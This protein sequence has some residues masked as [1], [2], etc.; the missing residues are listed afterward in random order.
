MFLAGQQSVRRRQSRQIVWPVSSACLALLS[1]TLGVLLAVPGEPRIVY[2]P[3]SVPAPAN[4][5]T[6]PTP[7]PKTDARLRPT[8]PPQA[9]SES[10][11]V[12]PSE[13]YPRRLAL[14]N[15]VLQ[16]TWG[17]SLDSSNIQQMSIKPIRYQDWRSLLDDMSLAERLPASTPPAFFQWNTLLN[18]KGS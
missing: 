15:R 6:V 17:T 14:R 11:V 7:G 10:P 18:T 1:I 8:V 13:W 2:V 16:D 4:T 9:P 5:H 12:V 3:Q